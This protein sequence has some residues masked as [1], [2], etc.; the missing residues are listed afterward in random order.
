MSDIGVGSDKA[1]GEKVNFAEG[2]RK[3]RFCGKVGRGGTKPRTRG[4]PKPGKRGAYR[5]RISAQSPQHQAIGAGRNTG[6]SRVQLGTKT[7]DDRDNGKGDTGRDEAVL[8]RR[9]RRLVVH[10]PQ[11]Q[12]AHRRPLRMGIIYFTPFASHRYGDASVTG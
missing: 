7:A 6:K 11:H 2:P 4:G 8:D 5:K 12:R 10:K 1:T 3:D 9:R